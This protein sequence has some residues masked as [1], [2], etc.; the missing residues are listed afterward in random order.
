[1][2]VPRDDEVG[3]CAQRRGE[4]LIVGGSRAIVGAMRAGA[5][6]STSAA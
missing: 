4:H 2:R 3:L 5:A 6:I 1:M